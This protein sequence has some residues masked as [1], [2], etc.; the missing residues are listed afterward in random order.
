MKVTFK[1]NIGTYSGTL[2]GMTYGSFRD[3]NLC[4]GRQWVQPAVTPQQTTLATV[5]RNLSTLY[6]EASE[7]WKADLKSYAYKYGKEHVSK[8]DYPPTAYAL[9]VKMMYSYKDYDSTNVDLDT[10]AFGDLET[11]VAPV[12]TIKGAIEA[13]LMPDVTG[14]DTLTAHI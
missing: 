4:I 8:T 9:Y 2:N 6:G 5:S 1:Y 3:G 12:I 7:A 10:I 13:G 14:S 11:L